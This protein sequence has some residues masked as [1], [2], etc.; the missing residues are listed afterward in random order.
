MS[1]TWPQAEEE[2]TN[3][4]NAGATLGC[5]V[6]ID[7]ATNAMTCTLQM[8]GGL[9]GVFK[10]KFY[11]AGGKEIAGTFSLTGLVG[12]SFDDGIVGAVALKRQSGEVNLRT[13]L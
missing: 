3:I 8:Q 10:G 6:T 4:L 7:P 2:N 13:S 5:T 1:S 12:F 9:S 11:G